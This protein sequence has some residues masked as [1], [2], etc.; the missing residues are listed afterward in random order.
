MSSYQRALRRLASR[1]EVLMILIHNEVFNYYNDEYAIWD[2][3]LPDLHHVTACEQGL[4][5]SQDLWQE[6]IL[7][8]NDVQEPLLA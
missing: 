6:G 4:K 2:G 8:E 5:Q 7:L 1:V 3:P